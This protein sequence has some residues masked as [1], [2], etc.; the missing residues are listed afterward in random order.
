MATYIVWTYA[1]RE[2][3]HTYTRASV[4]DSHDDDAVL[5][6]E[7]YEEDDD[8]VLVL[9]TDV[10]DWYASAYERQLDADSAVISYR[11]V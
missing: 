6:L 5:V 9:E 4:M 1:D 10:A 11:K 3:D 8:G 2:F 7:T